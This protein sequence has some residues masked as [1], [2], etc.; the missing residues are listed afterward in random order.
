MNSVLDGL[1][2]RRLEDVQLT[3]LDK[4]ALSIARC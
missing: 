1:R 4:I 3:I 2:E